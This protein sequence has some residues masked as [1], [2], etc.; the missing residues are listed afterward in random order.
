VR[1]K[2]RVSLQKNYI[3]VV[4]RSLTRDKCAFLLIEMYYNWTFSKKAHES[5]F[6]PWKGQCTSFANFD[7]TLVIVSKLCGSLA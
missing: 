2:L 6:Q 3:L 1:T 5:E 7:F 4:A